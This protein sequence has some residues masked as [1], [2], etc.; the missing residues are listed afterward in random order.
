[1]R[2]VMGV[3]EINHGTIEL[4]LGFD[5]IAQLDNLSLV[6]KPLLKEID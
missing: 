3:D 1:M 6:A 5:V 4:D 2:P